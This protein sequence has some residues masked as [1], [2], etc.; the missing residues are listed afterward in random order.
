MNQTVVQA[1]YLGLTIPDQNLKWNEERKAYDFSEPDWTEFKNVIKGNG[2]C[3]K[4]RLV[5]RNK[6][7]SDGEWV[8]EAAM[9]YGKKQMQESQAA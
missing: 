6:A 3:N 7:H 9:A 8:R 1:E 2:I 4:D 5:A